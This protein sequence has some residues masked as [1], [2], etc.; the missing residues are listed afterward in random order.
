MY[1]TFKEKWCEQAFEVMSK[2]HP[3]WPATKLKDKIENIFDK[4]FCDPGAT[5]VNNYRAVSKRTTLTGILVLIILIPI[6]TFAISP[7]ASLIGLPVSCDSKLAKRSLFS[8]TKST[9]LYKISP[10]S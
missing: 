6:L 2:A 9:N 10:L 4:K 1:Q 5:L 8:S 7:L 3:E